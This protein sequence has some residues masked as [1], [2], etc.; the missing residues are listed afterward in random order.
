M[1]RE[2]SSV[3]AAQRILLLLGNL[4]ENGAEMFA[5]ENAPDL[6]RFVAFCN[7]KLL[8]I[9]YTNIFML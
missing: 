9:S 2:A 4:L 7:P 8:I 1:R 3:Q 5:D 6:M